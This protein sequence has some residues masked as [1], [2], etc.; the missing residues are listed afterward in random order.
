MHGFSTVDGFVEISEN[1][2]EM[3]K[4]IAN[5]PSVGLFYI[6]QHTKNAVPN[7]VTLKNNV[8]T[9]SRET[10]LHSEDLEDS[11]AMSRSMKDCGLPIIDDMI[12]DIRNSL[13]LMSSKQPKR[14]LIR[15]PMSGFRMR[16]TSSLGGMA[17]GGSSATGDL[18]RQRSGN[19]FSSVI[20]SAKQNLRWSQ[21]DPQDPGQSKGRNPLFKS[22]DRRVSASETGLESSDELPLSSQVGEDGDEG[23]EEEDDD[24]GGRDSE[25]DIKLRSG[26]AMRLSEDFESFK[27]NREAKLEE[28]LGERTDHDNH[29]GTVTT[30]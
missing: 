21:L 5:E 11:I 15:N 13:A 14:G 18:G 3:I 23:D 22:K 16:R 2:A 6:Q 28:W 19:Y 12:S 24:E 10:S 30:T 20:N 9:K 29:N 7:V 1:L 27:A 8:T 17:W 4:Y 26:R 25:S